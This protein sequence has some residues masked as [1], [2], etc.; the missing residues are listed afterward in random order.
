MPEWLTT[1]LWIYAIGMVWG[2]GMCWL[3]IYKVEQSDDAIE[4]AQSR[5]AINGSGLSRAGF[6]A[7]AAVL[8]MPF[9]FLI[10]RSLITKEDS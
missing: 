2:A 5:Y 4:K 6:I 7:A 1:F 10:V 8:W 3:L 9:M